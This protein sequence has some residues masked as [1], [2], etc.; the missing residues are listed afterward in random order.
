MV[1]A[2]EW[3]RLARENEHDNEPLGSEK[4]GGGIF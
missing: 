3:I 4:G 1:E 2:V